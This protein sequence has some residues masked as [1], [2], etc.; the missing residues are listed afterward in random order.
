[1]FEQ[2]VFRALAEDLISESKAAELLRKSLSELHQL[3][4]LERAG[5]AD[6]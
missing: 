3:R 5:T 6:Q 2:L 4:N 1:L